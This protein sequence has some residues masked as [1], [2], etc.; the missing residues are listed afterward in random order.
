MS[1]KASV[2]L[3]SIKKCV[4][5]TD[6]KEVHGIC[7]YKNEIKFISSLFFFL[8]DYSFTHLW[9]VFYLNRRLGYSFIQIYTP[10]VLIV[11]LSWLSFWISKDAVPARVALVVTTV[12]TI[13][14]LMGSFRSSVPKVSILHGQIS[15][16][17]YF[18]TMC[19]I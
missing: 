15:I 4:T 9:A 1:S 7:S 13:V 14:T 5:E 18:P 3:C 16:A 17:R 8:Q 10:T 19:T 2:W 12:L 6:W 11:M